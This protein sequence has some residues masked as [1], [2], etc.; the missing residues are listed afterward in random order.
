M[1][2][3]KHEMMACERDS[4]FIYFSIKDLYFDLGR[5][6][7]CGMGGSGNA[8][9]ERPPAPPIAVLVSLDVRLDTIEIVLEFLTL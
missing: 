3:P 4:D 6:E 5:S 2:H 1:L 9:V 7:P 8:S